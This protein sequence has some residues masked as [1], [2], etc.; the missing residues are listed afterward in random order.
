MSAKKRRIAINVGGGFVPGMNGILMGA[1]AA[2]GE[3]GGEVV[4]IR[5][6]F[7][8][9]MH[10]DHYPDGG[11]V[12]L[13]EQLL[14]NVDPSGSGLLGQWARLDPFH[15]RRIDD[16]G[17]VEEVDLSGQVLDKLQAEGIDALISVVARRGLSI[18]YKLHRKGL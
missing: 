10:P 6:G 5:N 8:G 2:A 17:M 7:D 15:V 16:D 11:L 4:G 3:L 12:P 1:T 14:E 9:L 13:D 18:L